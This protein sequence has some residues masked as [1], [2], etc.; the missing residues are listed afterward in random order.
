M[1]DQE[2]KVMSNMDDLKELVQKASEGDRE[3]FE[4]LY[5][6]TCRS[7][8]FTCL[9]FLKEEQEA[10]DITQDVYLAALEKLDTLEDAEKFKPWLY[11]IA[12]NKSMN[13][14]KKMRPGLPGDE[15]LEGM[16]PED[17]ENFLP[18]DYALNTDKRELVLKIVRE[19]CSDVLYQTILLHYFTGF[20]IAEIAAIMECPEGTVKYRLSAAR[21]K[22]KEGVLRYEKKS[23]EKLR[24]VGAVPFLAALF[25]AQME[26]MQMPSLPTSILD[27]LPKST[28]AASTAKTGGSILFKSLQFKIAIGIVAAVVTVGGVATAAVLISNRNAE[29]VSVEG[30]EGNRLEKTTPE[31]NE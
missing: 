18:E 8:Y 17:N 3:A 16:K 9:G 24:S 21:A 31:T 30:Q 26:G 2:E 11:R 4:E 15:R 29:E 6:K 7:V 19:T 20:S 5:K 12:A 23:G 22:I 28:L 1:D 25:T 27:A 10:R 14:L 13:R